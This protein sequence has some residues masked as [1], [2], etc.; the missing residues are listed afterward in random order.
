GGGSAL[1]V[2][3]SVA[4]RGQVAHGVH[5]GEEEV[6]ATREGGERRKTFV[7]LT[8]RPF[9]NREIQSAVLGAADR[10]VFVVELVESLVVDP[11][12]LRELELA[13]EVGA[14]DERG[15]AGVQT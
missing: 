13:D 14:D 11:D 4:E 6:R 7:H 2:D 8:D 5:P 1:M 15:E 12:V 9:R 3:P 10:V